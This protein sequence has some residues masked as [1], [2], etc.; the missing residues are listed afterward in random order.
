[1]KNNPM[2]GFLLHQGSNNIARL[3]DSL[4]AEFNITGKQGRIIT[5]LARRPDE[6]ICQRD[7][8]NLI[9]IRRSTVSNLVD[10]L[11]KNGFI[12]RE[13]IGTDARIR[14]LVLSPK[15]FQTHQFIQEK[16]NIIENYIKSLYT[17]E[18]FIVLNELLIRLVK[19][20]KETN[21]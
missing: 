1:M 11:E 10:N 5:Y 20:T 14:R 7:I 3:L 6:V 21:V 16:I 19:G 18:E 9:G 4:T 15:G 12:T 13:L 17:E 8:E 2:L